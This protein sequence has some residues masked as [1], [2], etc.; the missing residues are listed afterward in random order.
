MLRPAGFTKPY[1]T[2]NVTPYQMITSPADVPERGS[3]NGGVFHRGQV[4]WVH[5][6]PAPVSVPHTTVGYVDGL[7]HV[8]IDP[9]VLRLMDGVPNLQN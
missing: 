8:L 6:T 2:T 9:R 5:E 3:S 7:G 4:V 1:R